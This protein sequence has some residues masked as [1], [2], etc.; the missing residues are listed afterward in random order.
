[1]ELVHLSVRIA[2]SAISLG[3]RHQAAKLH[4]DPVSLALQGVQ[5][6]ICCLLVWGLV[7]QGCGSPVWDRHPLLGCCTGRPHSVARPSYGSASL[8]QGAAVS[9]APVCVLLQTGQ[10]R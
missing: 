3:L 9:S 4:Q 2:P 10:A 8:K 6:R 5:P 7:L 1:M